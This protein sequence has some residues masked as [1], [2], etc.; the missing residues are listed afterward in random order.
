M[1]SSDQKT[2]DFGDYYYIYPGMIEAKRSN[3]E[4]NK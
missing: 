3:Q 4:E 1:T 2:W